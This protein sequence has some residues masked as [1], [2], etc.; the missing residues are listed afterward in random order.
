MAVTDSAGSSSSGPMTRTN[1]IRGLSGNAATAIASYRGEFLA[2]VVNISDV[3]S[4]NV[5][6]SIQDTQLDTEYISTKNSIRGISIPYTSPMSLKRTSLSEANMAV[7]ARQRKNSW[8]LSQLPSNALLPAYM[9]PTFADRSFTAVAPSS[10][11]SSSTA[12]SAS[13]PTMSKSALRPMNTSRYTG[14]RTIWRTRLTG[15]RVLLRPTFP[16]DI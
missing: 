11:I 3:V 2:M 5:K 12:I 16:L 6:S 15:R 7:I 14:M 1:A 8:S 4:S 13:I 9:A 10:G